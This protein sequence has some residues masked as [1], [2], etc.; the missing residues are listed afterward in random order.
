MPTLLE[1]YQKQTS[2]HSNFDRNIL[3][4]LR[5][6]RTFYMAELGRMVEINVAVI[7]CCL[8]SCVTCSR[9]CLRQRGVGEWSVLMDLGGYGLLAWKPD[10][11]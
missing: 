1:L 4:F 8:G 7:S 2:T 11:V 9:V 6:V 3:L 10:L 5:F